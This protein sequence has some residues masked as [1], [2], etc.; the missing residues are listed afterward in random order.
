MHAGPQTVGC[1]YVGRPARHTEKNKAHPSSHRRAGLSVRKVQSFGNLDGDNPHL[2]VQGISW[3]GNPQAFVHEIGHWAGIALGNS[4]LG[5][6]GGGC[7]PDAVA[8]GAKYFQEDCAHL[9]G[10]CTA[11]S[12]QQGPMWDWTDWYPTSIP[13]DK[14]AGGRETGQC[15]GGVTLGANVDA[16]GKLISF[17]YD[18]VDE[19]DGVNNGAMYIHDDL[20]LYMYGLKTADEVRTTYHCIGAGPEWENT[21]GGRPNGVLDGVNGRPGNRY[22]V[23]APTNSSF[24]IDDV[25]AAF[26]ERWPKAPAFSSYSKWGTPPVPH[27]PP[28]HAIST[29]H[30]GDR[31]LLRGC[32]TCV[33][34][35]CC[36][37][38]C[39]SLPW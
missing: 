6:C 22:N 29:S 1:L 27:P 13:C 33:R 23:Y 8:R 15:T 28:P 21:P 11:H 9:A 35:V 10:R 36:E 30:R 38:G 2:E 5:C 26:G 31:A 14:N 7:G 24:S 17:R 39:R 25:I 3:G 4:P 34:A 37:L 16:D 12:P 20:M 32:E 19:F 18:N